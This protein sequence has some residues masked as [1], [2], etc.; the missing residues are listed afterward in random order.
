MKIIQSHVCESVRVRAGQDMA[1][2]ALLIVTGPQFA[3]D[4]YPLC[5]RRQH[6]VSLERIDVRNM[7]NAK[8]KGGR[9]R[10]WCHRQHI[11][12]LRTNHGVISRT[13]DD[14]E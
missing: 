11:E 7:A 5:A 12:T 10:F 6:F 2:E 8:A 3:G 13:R 4:C 1:D 9:Y 14:L